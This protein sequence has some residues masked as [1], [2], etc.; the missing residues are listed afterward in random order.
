MTAIKTERPQPI[1]MWELPNV[2]NTNC[3]LQIRYQCDI[4]DDIDV[5]SSCG[6]KLHS[7]YKNFKKRFKDQRTFDKSLNDV[8]EIEWRA[9]IFFHSDDSDL[10][11][12]LFET[13]EDKLDFVMTFG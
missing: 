9:K 13:P 8:L 3:C 10:Q 5:F 2:Y 7:A 4:D 11:Y 12:L 6:L 1:D